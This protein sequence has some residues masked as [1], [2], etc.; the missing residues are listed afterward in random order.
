MIEKCLDAIRDCEGV[1]IIPSK[2]YKKLCKKLDKLFL[3]NKDPLISAS[4][5]SLRGVPIREVK[6]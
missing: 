2:Q 4:F 3:V 6:Q 5:Y 1:I